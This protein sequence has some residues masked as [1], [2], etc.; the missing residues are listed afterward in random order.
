MTSAA[1]QRV[2]QRSVPAQQLLCAVNHLSPA[3]LNNFVNGATLALPNVLTEQGLEQLG[4][5]A[6]IYHNPVTEESSGPVEV[7]VPYQGELS[8][9]EGLTRRLDPEHREAYL[10]LTKREFGDSDL[11]NRARSELE[12]YARANGEVLAPLRQ[13]DY[14]VWN[15]RGE[16]E[17]VG[18]LALPMR[19]LNQLRPETRGRLFP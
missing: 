9:P 10:T 14:G 2:Q 4:P 15:T 3:H 19:W 13:V 17:V 8:V 16:D 18:E 6:V 7:C 11:F 1:L 5:V 12:H